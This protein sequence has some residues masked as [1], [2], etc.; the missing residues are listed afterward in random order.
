[1]CI[2]G[3][4]KPSARGRE[5]ACLF[6]EFLVRHGATVVSG[7]AMGI[8]TVAHRTAIACGGSTIAVLGTPLDKVNPP[9]NADLQREIGERYLLVSQ[10][11]PGSN[12]YRRTSRGATARWRPAARV[13]RRCAS[14]QKDSH[15]PPPYSGQRR[16]RCGSLRAQQ[17]GHRRGSRESFQDPRSITSS[18]TSRG[19]CH[20]RGA[21]HEND[22]ARAYRQDRREGS[23]MIGRRTMW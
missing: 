9:S 16:R 13:P 20:C 21:A 2:I 23:I 6:A 15:W 11:A 8:D 3:T 18:T 1:V 5:S 7:L 17:V 10:F 22:G 14:P 4:R 12:V 19:W